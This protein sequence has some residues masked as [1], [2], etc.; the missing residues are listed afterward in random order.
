MKEDGA[1]GLYDSIVAEW[2]R[3]SRGFCGRPRERAP[4]DRQ[5]K[6]G[7][8]GLLNH[9]GQA[10]TVAEIGTGQGLLIRALVCLRVADCE[11]GFSM[12]CQG[13]GGVSIGYVQCSAG[14]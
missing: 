8:G 14:G 9:L 13:S 6:R 4:A 2:G 3:I 11:A 7:I 10:N 12:T 5:A 1:Q